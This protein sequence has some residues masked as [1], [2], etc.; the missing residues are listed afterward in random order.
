MPA[1]N[2]SSYLERRN[3]SV[4]APAAPALAWRRK[5]CLVAGVAWQIRGRRGVACASRGE[6]AHR[7][8]YGGSFTKSKCVEL[9]VSYFA[10]VC[11]KSPWCVA[12]QPSGQTSAVSAKRPN[13]YRC[14]EF[15]V[16]EAALHKVERIGGSPSMEQERRHPFALPY[17]V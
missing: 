13:T 17:V 7:P 2:F 4:C 3:G 10:T 12:F 16:L 14:G 1:K 6:I 8:E 11:R 9:G 5:R 15:I